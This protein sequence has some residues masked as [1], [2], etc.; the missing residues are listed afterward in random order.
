[1]GLI[2]RWRNNDDLIG[3]WIHL[4]DFLKPGE[5]KMLRRE[6]IHDRMN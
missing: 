6:L 3:P 2:L 1:M 4:F 5:E